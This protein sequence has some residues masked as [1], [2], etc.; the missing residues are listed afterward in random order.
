MKR[1]LNPYRSFNTDRQN[2]KQLLMYLGFT[3]VILIFT[4]ISIEVLNYLW[5]FYPG[6]Q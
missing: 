2:Q 5:N 6:N 4:V 3:F 1:N